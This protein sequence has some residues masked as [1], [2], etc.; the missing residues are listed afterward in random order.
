MKIKDIQNKELRKLAES[1]VDLNYCDYEEFLKNNG[2]DFA[3]DWQ[4]TKEGFK[5]WEGVS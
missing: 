5:F 3:F 2:L 4:E 1:R